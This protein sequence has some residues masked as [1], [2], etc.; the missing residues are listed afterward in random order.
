MLRAAVRVQTDTI[1]LCLVYLCEEVWEA[2]KKDEQDY[3]MPLRAA[4][5]GCFL[6]M[7]MKRNLE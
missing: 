2:L 6:P 3:V 5:G 4:K 7:R 1:D